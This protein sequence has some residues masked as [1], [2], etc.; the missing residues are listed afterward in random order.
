MT[1]DDEYCAKCGDSEFDEDGNET[2]VDEEK[3][4]H[5]FEYEEEEEEESLT[6][7]GIKDLADTVKSIAE[8]GKVLKNIPEIPPKPSRWKESGR[9]TQSDTK[10]E[11]RHRENIKWIKI[12]IAVGAV[13]AL[14]G[15]VF[16]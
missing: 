9:D 6:L 3:Y 11:K 8:A 16:F 2:H 10:Q 12:G 13:V 14:I 7:R 5:D 15:F 4:D 1:D